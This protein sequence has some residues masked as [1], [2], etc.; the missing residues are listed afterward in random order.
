MEHV[1]KPPVPRRVHSLGY[2]LGVRR[3]S[4]PVQ[5]LSTK[6]TTTRSDEP[7]GSSQLLEFHRRDVNEDRRCQSLTPPRQ[8]EGGRR[9]RS[10]QY[11]IL[12]PRALV[13]QTRV[14]AGK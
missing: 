11:D 3:Q 2:K 12:G 10:P 8:I 6:Q 4:A 14:E 9:C 13:R 1:D 5:P 7:T